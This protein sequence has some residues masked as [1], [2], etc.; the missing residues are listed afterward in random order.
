VDTNTTKGSYSYLAN[1]PIDTCL[2][3]EVRELQTSSSNS[4][5]ALTGLLRQTS[6]C[7]RASTIGHKN[8]PKTVGQ[9]EGGYVITDMQSFEA[10]AICWYSDLL[11]GQRADDQMGFDNGIIVA[12]GMCPPITLKEYDGDP[13]P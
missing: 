13:E 10:K 9:L 11:L 1:K 12:Y 4:T 2:A 7:I 6:V 3:P 8:S 5:T